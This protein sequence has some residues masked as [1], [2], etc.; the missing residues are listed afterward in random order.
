MTTK[1]VSLVAVVVFSFSAFAQK[2]REHSTETKSKV[3]AI[4][5]LQGKEANKRIIEDLLNTIAEGKSKPEKL[6]SGLNELFKED[7]V[8]KNKTA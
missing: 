7:I 3:E 1:F 5:K 6:E 4:S 2:A 8:E